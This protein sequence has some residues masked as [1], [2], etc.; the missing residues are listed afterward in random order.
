MKHHL[1]IF[2]IRGSLL[3][4]TLLWFS[5]V[6]FKR[7]KQGITKPEIF[8]VWTATVL[9]ASALSAAFAMWCIATL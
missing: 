1:P 5:C 7:L 4:L 6:N 2:A 3:A 9:V 8:E